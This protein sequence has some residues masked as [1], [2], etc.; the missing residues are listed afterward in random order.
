M[1]MCPESDSDPLNPTQIWGSQSHTMAHLSTTAFHKSSMN[2]CFVL[3]LCWHLQPFPLYFRTPC[4]LLFFFSIYKSTI[5]KVTIF[6][7]LIKKEKKTRC[8]LPT[9]QII[10]ENHEKVMLIH[11]TSVEIIIMRRPKTKDVSL[12]HVYLKGR[13]KPKH[14]SRITAPA[15]TTDLQC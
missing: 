7:L 1:A 15:S 10:Q 2:I 8:S 9:P 13:F 12:L 11:T 6:T 4:I 5:K 3:N 14:I